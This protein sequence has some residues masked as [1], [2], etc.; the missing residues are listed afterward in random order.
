MP[1]HGRGETHRFLPVGLTIVS[2]VVDET[3]KNTLIH[4]NRDDRCGNIR[5]LRDRADAEGTRD[6]LSRGL[7]RFILIP[8]DARSR[9]VSGGIAGG[10]IGVPRL[11][12]HRP[13]LR[14]IAAGARAVDHTDAGRL[15][16]RL[17]GGA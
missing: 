10:H 16:H 1:L 17:R 3:P 7:I 14:G 12:E 4:Q 8:D 11:G 13:F 15:V 6:I 5:D 2:A 9:Q